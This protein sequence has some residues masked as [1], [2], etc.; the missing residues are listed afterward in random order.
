MSRMS[1]V[2]T[3][4][5]ELPVLL[6][7]GR[8]RAG[9]EAAKQVRGLAIPRRHLGMEVAYALLAQRELRDGALHE[10]SRR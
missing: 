6:T 7:E 4:P 10:A 8:V 2:A 5:D 1:L 9:A 3:A